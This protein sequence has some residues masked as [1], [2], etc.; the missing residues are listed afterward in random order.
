[1]K[2]PIL[3]SRKNKKNIISLSSAESASSM[4][5]VKGQERNL[6]RVSKYLRLRTLGKIFSGQIFFLF[7]SRKTG[8]D[9][10]CKLSQWR[11]FA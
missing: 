5:S 4:V 11:Q 2:H 10:T 7:F 8:F 3:F 1:M 9:I 6:V